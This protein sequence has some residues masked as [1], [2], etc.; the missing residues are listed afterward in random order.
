MCD[1][2]TVLRDGKLVGEYEIKD[3]PR[4]K[5][6]AKM[7]G[8]ELDD[9]S[10]IRDESQVY[11]NESDTPIFEAEGLQSDAGIRLLISLK[12]ERSMVLPGFLV[13]DGANAS[14]RFS[15]QTA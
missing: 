1:K 7:L 2:I 3:L 5:L 14:V 8:K 11:H 12:R 9:M 4:V 15:G 10:D 6:V 13:P